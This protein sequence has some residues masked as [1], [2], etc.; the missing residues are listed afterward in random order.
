MT[1]NLYA[2]FKSHFPSNSDSPALITRRDKPLSYG[3]LDSLS[4][5]LAGLL[6]A[7]GAVPGDRV[8]VQVE[9]STTAVALYLACLRAG[10]VYLPLNTAYL[11]DELEY[12]IDDAKP[13]VIIGEADS[14]TLPVLAKKHGAKSFLTLEANGEGTLATLAA[15]TE[16]LETIYR[17]SRDD[18]AA[19]L[20]SSGTTGRPKGVML[21]HANLSSN[22]QTLHQLWQFGPNDVLLHTLPI[23]HTHGLFAALNTT[24]LNGTA[25]L[26]HEKFVVEQVI[27][28]L[29][30]ATVFMGVP[31]YYVRLLASS[32][33][34][35]EVCE[36]MRLFISG[37]AP[38]VERTFVDFEE[39]T[40]HQL[41]E[42]YGMTEAGMI[43]SAHPD[44][45]RQ[46][47]NVGWPLPGV[48]LR[49]NAQ[50]QEIEIRGPNV[51]SGYWGKPT[52]TAASFTDDMYFKTGDIGHL[53]KDG[54]IS[55]I[56]RA[57][58]MMI[59][60]GFNVYPKE[61][62]NFIDQISGVEESAVV[63]M[64][65]PDFGEAGLAVV[66]VKPGGDRLTESDVIESLKGQLAN[67]KVP[68]AIVFVDELPRN[69]MGKVQK[70]LLRDHYKDL[71]CSMLEPRNDC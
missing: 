59:S 43:T 14:A 13:S 37:S 65:H 57:K 10:L 55:V 64:P 62:E 4:A 28:D 11:S 60:G 35:R 66:S 31:T 38:L 29:K 20:Y 5:R 71:W 6:I 7:I 44:K 36:G 32:R 42:R 3:D 9:K 52:E 18:L 30:K 2:L 69:A 19:I 53:Y 12:F 21:S 68:K 41:L 48:S 50:N 56:G 46:P 40:G 23:F 39:R 51:F 17:N 33:F 49:L 27:E 1:A 61:V 26:F 34:G 16:P 45:P 58:D 47:G 63:G 54:A 67:Y 8:A 24:L 15:E 22:A 70:A 25:I